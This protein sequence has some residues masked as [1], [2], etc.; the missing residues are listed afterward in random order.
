VR[1]SAALE[2]PGAALPGASAGLGAA[3]ILCILTIYV[4]SLNL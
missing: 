3:L 4:L 2:I 1:L